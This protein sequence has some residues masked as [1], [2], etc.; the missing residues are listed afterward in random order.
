MRTRLLLIW[1]VLFFLI[2]QTVDAQKVLLLQKPG[3]T[4]RYFYTTGDKI[5]VRMGDPEFDVSGEITYIDDS[6]VLLTETIHFSFRKF[7]KYI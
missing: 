7:T 3:K 5:A 6:V 1:T 2:C 4:K